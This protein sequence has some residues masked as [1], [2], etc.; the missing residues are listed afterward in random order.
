VAFIGDSEDGFAAFWAR[1]ARVRIIAEILPKDSPDFWGADDLVT[2][3]VIKTFARIQ[4]KAIVAEKV[5]AW[6]S[7]CDPTKGW[8]RIG[9][10]DYCLLFLPRDTG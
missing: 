3:R 6:S 8:Q 7:A 4:A 2:S 5:S 1:L 10:T 9:K